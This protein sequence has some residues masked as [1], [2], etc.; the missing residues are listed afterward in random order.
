MST[1]QRIGAADLGRRVR[2]FGEF[3]HPRKVGPGRVDAGGMRGRKMRRWS[4]M[5][6]VSGMAID[7]RNAREL[8][9]HRMLT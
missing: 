1:A 7:D 4:I 8:S 9:Q 6:R 2:A 5:T 3:Q